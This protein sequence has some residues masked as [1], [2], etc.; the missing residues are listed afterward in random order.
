MP[1]AARP[2]AMPTPP[3]RSAR[4]G[5]NLPGV[6]EAERRDVI[7]RL[8]N[9]AVYIERGHPLEWHDP[10]P[11]GRKGRDHN[12]HRI[13]SFTVLDVAAFDSIGWD[14]MKRGWRRPPPLPR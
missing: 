5:S 11:R 13:L 10:E 3:T 9:L 4:V 2:R 12:H 6:D 8:R 1:N 7:A 14:L